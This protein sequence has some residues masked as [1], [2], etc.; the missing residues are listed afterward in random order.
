MTLEA[1]QGVALEEQEGMV[2]GEGRR[3]ERD[4]DQEHASESTEVA[5]PGAADNESR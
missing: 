3:G 2:A 5:I 1:E 4:A